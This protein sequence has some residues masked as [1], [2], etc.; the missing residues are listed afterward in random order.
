MKV[1]IAFYG[2]TRSLK[3]TIHSIHNQILD[4]L[5]QN[6]INYTIFLHTY[7]L[8]KYC[9]IRTGENIDTI[10]NEEYKLLNPDYVIIDEQEIVKKNINM[11]LYRTHKDPWNT[12]YNSVD[13][14][15][16]AQYSKS[17]VVKMIEQSEI[18]FDYILF[19]RPDCLYLKPFDVNYFKLVNNN[20]ICIPNFHL[21]G[22]YKINDRFCIANSK[23]YKMYGLIFPYLLNMSKKQSLHSETIIGEILYR[24]RLN[25]KRIPFI[26]SRVRS[27][28]KI[29]DNLNLNNNVDEKDKL[30]KM[31][32]NKINKQMSINKQVALN[33]YNKKLFIY[34]NKMRIMKIN[35]FKRFNRFNRFNRLK[36][37]KMKLQHKNK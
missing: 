11:S 28:G 36:L 30:N 3:H 7:I 33:K 37:L 5:K 17:K 15:I 6:N 20:T 31:N 25:I 18:P 23:T 1:A 32:K 35:R 16:L 14:F 8:D 9:N 2:I 27:C 12:N 26:F 29:V 22:K 10:N 13:N 34:R 21:H 24:Y 19:V 4:V